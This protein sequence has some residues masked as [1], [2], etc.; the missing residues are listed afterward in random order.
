MFYIRTEKNKYNIDVII[1]VS[2]NE[3]FI[4]NTG[5]EWIKID[6]EVKPDN[7]SYF[8][9]EQ[10]IPLG[11]E[12]YHLIEEIIFE[13]EEPDRIE[14]DKNLSEI[15][16]VEENIDEEIIEIIEN[17]QIA[18]LDPP[19]LTQEQK[20]EI[21]NLPKPKLNILD[22]IES[23]Q[24]NYEFFVKDLKDIDT[25][26]QAYESGNYTFADNEVKFE[27]PVEFPS[28]AILSIVIIPLSLT[29]EEQIQHLKQQKEIIV[30]LLDR[31]KTDLEIKE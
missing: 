4:K 20:Q 17:I 14:R 28:G 29:L 26:I 21:L 23:T 10:I 16:E 12:N 7:G 6:D 31:I 3:D 8:Y 2:D 9:N 30:N 27:P 5:L 11:S 13:K 18:N 25:L 24:E 19:Q 22:D 15:L 1:D